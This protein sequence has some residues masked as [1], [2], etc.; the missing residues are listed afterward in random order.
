M[1]T[2]TTFLNKVFLVQVWIDLIVSQE[3]YSK[4]VNTYVWFVEY[5][6]LQQPCIVSILVMIIL[7]ALPEASEDSSNTAIRSA[8]IVQLLNRYLSLN[9][10]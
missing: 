2:Y 5:D 1:S 9:V 7:L 3:Y 4:D 8:V 10:L 6:L